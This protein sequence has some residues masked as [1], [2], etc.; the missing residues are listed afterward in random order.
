LTDRHLILAVARE[1][2]KLGK[3][4]MRGEFGETHFRVIEQEI[5]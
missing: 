1:Y 5:M 3:P 2:Q 4:L